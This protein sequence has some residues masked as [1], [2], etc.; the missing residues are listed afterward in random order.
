MSSSAAAD[1]TSLLAGYAPTGRYDEMVDARGRLREPWQQV[2][3]A[4]DLLGLHELR[5]RQDEISQLLDDDG[6]HYHVYTDEEHPPRRPREGRR[7]RLDPVPVV[8][9]SAEWQVLERGVVQRAELLEAV[10]ADLHG[11]QDL[12]RH[13]L[14]PP[15]VVHGHPG[16]LRPLVG[17]RLPG[18]SQLVTLAFDIARDAGGHPMVVSDRTQAP[19]GAGYALTNRSVVSRVFPS[20]FRNAAVHRLAPYLRSLRAALQ[21]AAPS[22]TS[23]EPRIV[24]LSPGPWNETAFEHAFLAN[25]LGF[26]LV[27]GADL[28]VRDGRVHLRSLDSLE[29]VDVILRRVDAEWCDPLELRPDSQL[30]VP[31]LVDVVRR[32]NVAVA[33]PL[34]SGVLENPALLSLLPGISRAVLGEDLRL[35]SVPSW[36][37]GDDEGL[38]YVLSHLDEL[39]VKPLGR[40][41]RRGLVHAGRLSS[42]D[43]EELR[44]RIEAE[45]WAWVGQ[46]DVELTTSPVVT[47]DGLEP[48]P[49]LLRTFVVAHEGSFLAMPG[50]LTRVAARDR[51]LVSNQSGAIAKDTWVVSSEPEVGGGW[52]LRGGPSVAAIAPRASM[53]AR[54]AENLFWFG[55]YAERAE[56]CV[57]VLRTVARRRTELTGPSTA[58]QRESVDVLLEAVTQVTATFP[59]FAGEAGAELRGTPDAEL[60]SLATDRD[61]PGSLAFAIDR[62]ADAAQVV[63]DQL[64]TDTWTALTTLER[65]VTLAGDQLAAPDGHGDVAMYG[66]VLQ[67]LL[68]IQGLA[69]EGMVRDPGWRFMD[70]GRRVERALTVVGLL[71]AVL[72][73]ERDV[74]TDSLLLESV[75]AAA[76]SV[77]TYRRRYRS[78][79]QLATALDLLLVDVDNPRSVAS[80]LEQLAADLQALPT[81]P[82]RGRVSDPERPV[83]AATTRIRLANTSALAEV[84]DGRRPALDDLLVSLRRDLR[85]AADL[86]DAR[87]F[88]HLQA[89]RSV[90]IGDHDVVEGD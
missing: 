55:R 57:R 66:R 47:P 8:V 89:Q 85:E 2:G 90:A 20:L 34:G 24:V 23:G 37:C 17:T 28:V 59:G 52:W 84:V 61:R 63:R 27:E 77:V 11:P 58:A 65:E 26:G 39:L 67:S 46:Q 64:S 3:Q 54:A 12:L 68:A 49:S 79:G 60:L 43:R 5:R 69:A 75:L 83:L 6:V 62:M 50:G 73:V 16:F 53:S 29:P 7:W 70:A 51:W 80:Q 33:N 30:G 4:L 14:V 86:V 87:H 74:R 18:P 31:G 44:H 76:E 32:G 56:G 71:R 13:G 42:A 82:G 72:V 48:R 78:T 40:S 15:A 36:W 41:R 25:E 22:T 88:T 45:P 1:A 19:S 81:H 38:R 9:P 10:L 21:A 35:A